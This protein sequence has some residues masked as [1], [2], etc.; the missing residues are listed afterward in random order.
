MFAFPL[1][2]RGA[3]RLPDAV[4]SHRRERSIALFIP[5]VSRWRTVRLN[6]GG[7]SLRSPNSQDLHSAI[8]SK[9]CRRQGSDASV[10]QQ[11]WPE[12][13]NLLGAFVSISAFLLTLAF[14][15]DRAVLDAQ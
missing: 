2:L 9:T 7:E 4:T 13:V 1:Y 11:P 12:S 10:A 5:A 6:S 14:C 15:L 3:R 8:L